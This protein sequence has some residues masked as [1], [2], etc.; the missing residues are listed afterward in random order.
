[1]IRLN[2]QNSNCWT[3]LL[4]KTLFWKQKEAAMICPEFLQSLN[5]QRHI[6]FLFSNHF[7][8]CSD[9]ADMPERQ[10]KKKREKD[11][12]RRKR[13]PFR[14][15][16]FVS[17]FS[18]GNVSL[19]TFDSASLIIKTNLPRKSNIENLAV[20]MFVWLIPLKKYKARN[21]YSVIRPG[22]S[23]DRD[24]IFSSAS[25]DSASAINWVQLQRGWW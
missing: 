11:C 18:V 20:I 2:F 14:N 1:M 10:K 16:V 23:Y 5:Y 7:F 17:N 25:Y 13:A 12:W 15:S 21:P 6:E 24:E 3:W 19:N 22:R 9:W 4:S 8:K